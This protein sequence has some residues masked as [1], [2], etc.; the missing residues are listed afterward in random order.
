MWRAKREGPTREKVGREEE[1]IGRK[2]K[3]E[4]EMEGMRERIA[5][6]R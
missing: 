2:D 3:K 4:K 6:W 5:D 1:P